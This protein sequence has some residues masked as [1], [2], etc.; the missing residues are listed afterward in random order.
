[1]PHEG[2]FYARGAPHVL[3]DAR[4]TQKSRQGQEEQLAWTPSRGAVRRPT[5]AVTLLVGDIR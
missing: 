2:D 5:T 1:M 3:P 4:N